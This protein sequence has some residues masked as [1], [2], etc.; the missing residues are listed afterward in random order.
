VMYFDTAG[1]AYEIDAPTDM[2]VMVSANAVA[3]LALGILPGSLMALCVN[4]FS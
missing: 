1:E 3:V 4:V 2:R